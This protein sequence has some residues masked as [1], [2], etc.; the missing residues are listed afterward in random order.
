MSKCDKHPYWPETCK[1]VYEKHWR[2][3]IERLLITPDDH[4][5]AL[6]GMMACMELAFLCKS[7]LPLY[8]KDRKKQARPKQILDSFFPPEDF[9]HSERLAARLFNGLK[10]NAY[11][12]RGV[13]LEDTVGGNEYIEEPIRLCDCGQVVLIAPTAFWKHVKKQIEAIYA[14]CACNFDPREK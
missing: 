13:A 14:K 8:P 10:H 6:L 1:E 12:R 11:V 7:R 5:F 9:P 4:P 2:G 3:Q